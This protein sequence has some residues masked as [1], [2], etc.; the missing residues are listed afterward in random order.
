MLEL[1]I[2][3][4]SEADRLLFEGLPHLKPVL[5]ELGDGAIVIGGLATTAWIETS[6]LDLPLRATRDVDLGIDRQVLRLGSSRAKVQPL[7]RAQG[8]EPLLV[9]HG[10]RFE[11][12]TP[13][14]KFLIDLLVAPGASRADP[15]LL[16]AGMPSLAAP[17]LAYAIKR[18]PTHLK[19]TLSDR[20]EDRSFDLPVVKLDAAVVMKGA[21]VSGG[22]RMKPDKRITDTSDAIMLAAACVP[23]RPSIEQLRVHRRRKDVREAV[24][25]LTTAFGDEKTAAARRVERHFEAEFAQPGGAAWAVEA[26]ARFAEQLRGAF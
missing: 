1:R 12:Q 19:L 24:S 13:A 11:R 10:F 26:A 4:A 9:D 5:A 6:D 25:W 8:F 21:L 16:E 3:V 18:R 2:L 14:G 20:R 15:P 7:L 23:D 22:M 17:G